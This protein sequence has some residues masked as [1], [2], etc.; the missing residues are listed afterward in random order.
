MDKNLKV[1]ASRNQC[2]ACLEYFNSLSGF[3]A[4]RIG[5][6]GV[7]RRCATA[8]EMRQKGMSLNPQ[9]YWITREFER[10]TED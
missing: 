8:E 9:E 10:F 5:E 1:G 7:D 6:F 4:H 3:D 2:R